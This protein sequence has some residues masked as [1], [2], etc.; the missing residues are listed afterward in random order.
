[1]LISVI[2]NMENN[3]TEQTRTQ[4]LKIKYQ[5]YKDEKCGRILLETEVERIERVKKFDYLDETIQENGLE[6]LRWA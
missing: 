1:M 4:D 5:I 2:Q 3:K 6:K